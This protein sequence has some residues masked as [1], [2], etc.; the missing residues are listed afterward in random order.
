MKICLRLKPLYRSLV[1][2]AG[3]SIFNRKRV[4]QSVDTVDL[5]MRQNWTAPKKRLLFF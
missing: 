2:E 4:M 5:G 1:Y 3:N